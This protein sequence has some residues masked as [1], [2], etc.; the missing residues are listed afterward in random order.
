M[1]SYSQDLRDRV[2]RAL[3]RGD[4]PTEIA[5]RYEVSRDWVY[6][7]RDR[8]LQDGTRGGRQRG[9]YRASRLAGMEAEIRGWLK[10]DPGLTL[11]QLAERLEQ[12]AVIIKIPALWH[13]MNKWDLSL[14]KNPARPRART[15]RRPEIAR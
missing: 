5:R 12:A 11:A 8:F 7:V 9:G 1:Q 13:Q 2:L 3:D 10:E 6:Q 4:G 15:A 14:K